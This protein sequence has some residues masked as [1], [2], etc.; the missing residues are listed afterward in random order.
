MTVFYYVR[1][2]GVAEAPTDFAS[3]PRFDGT[4]THQAMSAEEFRP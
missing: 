4:V 2:H 1:Y 3:F